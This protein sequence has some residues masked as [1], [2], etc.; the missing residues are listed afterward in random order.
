MKVYITGIGNIS[1][2]NT[3]I[4]GYFPDEYLEY[5]Q[6]YLTSVEPNYKDYIEPLAR[7]RMGKVIRR[8]IV[9]STMALQDAG[10]SMPDAIITGTG[11]GSIEE[12]ENFLISML[13]HNESMLNPTP[14]IQATYNSISTQ[15]AIHLNCKAYNSTYVHRGLSF[16]SA[17]MDAILLLNEGSAKNVLVGGADEITK[18]HYIIAKRTGALKKE[19]ISNSELLNSNTSGTIIGEGTVFFVLS[20]QKLKS[21]YATL[22]GTKSLFKDISSDEINL[23]IVEFLRKYNLTISN[24]DVFL[25]GICGI[26]EHDSVYYN[27]ASKLFP[28]KTLAYYKHLCGEYFTSTGFA[29]WLASNMIKRNSIPSSVIVQGEK[30]KS[31]RHILCYNRYNLKEHSLM[32]ISAA[33]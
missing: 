31:I 23:Q 21:T 16:E 17:L 5:R 1:P 13:H 27:A 4:K 12:T 2:Q 11:H 8:A 29:L 6:E 15:I 26:H 9:A 18:N 24:I 3:I 14:F 33:E 10:L 28:E 22:T 30:P 20:K 25:T 32:L 7:R 19:I